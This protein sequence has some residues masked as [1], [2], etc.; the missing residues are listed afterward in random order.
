MVAAG[1]D[2]TIAEVAN[3]LAGSSVLLAV[4]P[5]GTANVLARELRLPFSPDEIVTALV[6]GRT[7]Q[8]W[9]GIVST[10]GTSR[11]F[12]Q[13]V[14]VGFDAQV[15]QGVSSALK[16]AIGRSAYVAQAVREITRY[17]YKPITLYLDG[18]KMETC[19]AI[20]CKGRL[21][22]G[23]FLLAPAA[24]IGERGF[25]VAL[26]D[27]ASPIKLLK[28]GVALPLNLLGKMQS[29]RYV[30]AQRIS[31]RS[32]VPAQADGDAIGYAPLAITDAPAPIQIIVG[33]AAVD[34]TTE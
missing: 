23:Q 5:L 22:G 16:R 9:P 34:A 8:I 13:M 28:Y 25:S 33:S 31:F 21:Y 29:V 6:S 7:R 24:R 26:F 17:P 12:L 15:V 1:G 2:G 10:M 20:V 4:V 27:A 32:E 3:G 19:S 30:Y 14:G 18:I 11:M